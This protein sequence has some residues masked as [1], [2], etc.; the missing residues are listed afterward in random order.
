REVLP[1]PV[2]GVPG[3]VVLL[4]ADPDGEVVVDP[5]AGEQVRQRVAR[6]LALQVVADPHR[7]DVGGPAAALVQG[8]QERHAA[9]RVMLPAVLA[10]EDYADQGPPAGPRPA[11]GPQLAD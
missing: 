4:V 2:Q 9:A 5:A 1:G 7:L 3:G 8:A 6:R 10:V 11:D